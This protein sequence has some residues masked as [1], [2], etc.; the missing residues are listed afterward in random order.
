MAKH[1]TS[2]PAV[3]LALLGAC[4][5][6]AA[7]ESLWVTDFNAA[8]DQAERDGRDLLIDFTGSD[9][10]MWCMKLKEEVFSQPAFRAEAPK[11]FV[12]VMLDFPRSKPVS[13]ANEMLQQ[14]FMVQGFPTIVLADS[15]GRAYAR[16][17]YRGVGAEKYLAHLGELRK[18][19]AER[20]ELF[21]KAAQAKG[22]EKARLLDQALMR[23]E[24]DG[25]LV[26][27][28]EEVQQIVAADADNKA[29]LKKKYESRARIEQIEKTL[30]G[31]RDFKAAV[32][33]VDAF[34]K[35]MDPAPESRQYALYLKGAAQA[36]QGQREEALATLQAAVEAAPL[37]EA[38]QE[39]AK[40]VER[41]KAA[42]QPPQEKEEEKDENP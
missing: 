33:K 1:M 9:W 2:L 15:K 39:I 41:V 13:A 37:T 22:A 16:T 8:L 5:G 36:T 14:E 28:G 23:L 6:L 26:G 32:E 38:A 19:K 42:G 12:L 17:G 4:A 7:E 25:A 24:N 40:V 29:G 30:M 27:Y 35:E 20:D 18:S 11:Q 34:L 31:A 3:V 10:C 21:A